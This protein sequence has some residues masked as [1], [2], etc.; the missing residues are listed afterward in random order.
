MRK[1]GIPIDGICVAAGVPSLDVANEIVQSCKSCGFR[2]I[3]FKPGT[4]DAI[5]RV[6]AIAQ[7]NS[8]FPIILQWTGG[9]SG[10]HHSFE[11][12]HQPLLETYSLIRSRKN[13]V[14]VVGSGFGDANGSLPYLLGEWSKKF[15]YPPMPVDGILLA[16]RMLVS[17]ESLAS[18]QTKQ[19]IVDTPGV[20]NES[21]WVGTYKTETGGVLTV[22]SELGEPIH[23]IATRGV[24]LWKELDETIF[25]LPKE[26]RL[27]VL[28]DKKEYIIR[29]LNADY[30]RV[31]FG[32]RLDG[33]VVDLEDMTYYEVAIR[34]LEL[35]Y[36]ACQHRW[37]DVSYRRFF[38]TFLQRVEERFTSTNTMTS[39]LD[40]FAS[41]QDPH[42]FVEHFFNTYSAS[43]TFIPTLDERFEIYFKKDSLWGAEDIDA[44]PGQDAGRVCILQGPVAAKYSTKVNEPVK[45]IL[46]NIEKEYIEHI[47]KRTYSGDEKSVPVVEYVGGT[48]IQFSESVTSDFRIATEQT[49]SGEVRIV[50]M[51]ESPQA[52]PNTTAWLEYLAG[53]RYSWI[54]ALITSPYIVQGRLY[55]R[56]VIRALLQPHPLQKFVLQFDKTKTLICL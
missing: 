33:S 15:G 53:N 45:D 2:H 32:K 34:L 30:Q 55:Q 26:Q 9:R 23:M 29:R 48:P 10:G 18:L 50:E 14:L 38:L 22:T 28:R 1:E 7:N 44:I 25:S 19:M 3:A 39:L 16:S 47:L 54:R 27:Q 46:G 52:L 5:R 24:K 51:P 49:N 43:K 37:I 13:I 42:S 8:D 35:M 31:W 4:A 6:V 56:N 36:V 41:Y 12:F 11:D 20:Q 21:E 40:S 17:K